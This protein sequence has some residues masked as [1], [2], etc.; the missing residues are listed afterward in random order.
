MFCTRYLASKMPQRAGMGLCRRM[1][2]RREFRSRKFSQNASGKSGG[3][4]EEAAGATA[5]LNALGQLNLRNVGTFVGAGLG[6]YILSNSYLKTDAGITYVQQ[7]T[8]TGELAV[9]TEPGFHFRVPFFSNV[10]AYKQVITASFGEAD[11]SV[12]NSSSPVQ[13]RFAD[14]YIGA[15]PSTFRFR[16]SSDADQVRKMHRDF[17]S[18]TRLAN[19]LLARNCRNVVIITATQYTGEEF[20]Q[21]SPNV[22]FELPFF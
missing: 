11:G 17:R 19:T 14:T 8:L 18:E 2:Q 3:A 16:L 21:V 22:F 12:F 1:V 15:V 7:N 6:I 4:S 20:F 10:T 13:V 9:Y 5:W